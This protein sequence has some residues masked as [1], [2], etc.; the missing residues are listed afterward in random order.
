[1]HLLKN[2]L[3]MVLILLVIRGGYELSYPSKTPSH[4][5]YD[6][7]F[8]ESVLKHIHK[9]TEHPHAVGQVTHQVVGRY[10][11]RHVQQLNNPKIKINQ[12]RSHYYNQHNRKAAALTNYIIQYPGQTEDAPAVMLMAHYDAARFSASGA[13][14]DAAG[15]A[16][17]LEIF[18]TFIQQ[19]PAPKNKLLLLITDGEELGLL[20]ANAFIEDQLTYHDIGV[21]INLE[22]RGS[23]GPAILLPETDTGTRGLIEAYQK[24][25]VPMPV[26]SSLDAEIYAKMPN[27][28][29][30]TPFKEHGI[31]AFNLA[32][33]D[34]HFNYHSPTDDLAHLSLNSVAHHLIQSKS[35][36]NYLADT[37][38][39][40]LQSD[41]SPVYFSVP[42]L[43]I[44][45]Y[46]RSTSLIIFAVLWLS[47]LVLLALTI[48]H[49]N[50]GFKALIGGLKP[51]VMTTFFV[52]IANYILLAAV[53]TL[54]PGWKDILQGFP[55]GGHA[56]I[57]AQLFLSL[58]IVVLIYRRR[59]PLNHAGDALF[60]LGIWLIAVSFLSLSLPG[61][62]FLIIPAAAALPVAFLNLYKPAWA[63]QLAPF[64]L[65]LALLPLGALLVNLPVALGIWMTPA[66]MLILVLM[67]APL[68]AWI[69]G[70]QGKDKTA[71]LLIIPV[72][73]CAWVVFEYRHFTPH[74]PLPTSI[75]YLNDVDNQQAYLFHADNRRDDWLSD[76]F[77]NPL[78][79]EATQDFQ[80]TYK[81]PLT[82]LVH[83]D[84]MAA[85]P[86]T[87][88]ARK[89]LNQMGHQRVDVTVS[90]HPDTAIVS[91]YTRQAMTLH[92][93][94]VGGRIH[95]F[96]TPMH[97]AAGYKLIEYHITDNPTFTLQ[98][99][100]TDDSV[101]DWQI[102]SHREGLLA[103]FNLPER[104]DNQMMKPF[105]KT[106]LITTVQHW[107]LSDNQ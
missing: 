73:Y 31:N 51:L 39:K 34:D 22:A 89:P 15:V 55:Y 29:D 59:L 107:T 99:A 66:A 48:S 70:I 11:E 35:L 102:Q 53:Y 17:A 12:H 78:S 1:M 8:M 79:E 23:S 30:V 7:V 88:K 6:G 60:S 3:F 84:L 58:A 95:R 5:I 56:L 13:A 47:W 86:A 25:G 65:L 16:V 54:I 49:K 76:L 80:K 71:W 41:A 87:V 61:A 101:L 37:D 92:S 103:E 2:T 27:D 33:I 26:S 91:I 42:T 97:I 105:I 75:N 52:F 82:T 94:A 57:N 83:S 21:I 50:H 64:M 69:E 20:G 67:M 74:Q 43:G 85:Y 81:K 93:L 40:H 38:L 14:D 32:F 46:S 62:G 9:I 44:L 36:L 28:T 10:L 68:N 72:F 104:P 19:N 18:K 4:L 63:Q 77:D 100:L 24:A 98:L 106:D 96:E 90:A 45:S